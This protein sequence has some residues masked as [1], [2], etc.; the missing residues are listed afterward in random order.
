M[1]KRFKFTGAYEPHFL[2][3]WRDFRGMSL[4]AMVEAIVAL[5]VVTGGLTKASLSRI[6]T[7]KTPYT[8][9]TLEAYAAV[10]GCHPADL[11]GRAPVDPE[12]IWTIWARLRQTDR[13]RAVA[14]LS[15]LI[16]GEES[17]STEA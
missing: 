11:L 7:G 9:D 2:R 6:E 10:L 15:L 17:R 8:R 3:Q 4:D 12:G 13:P 16:P 1:A 14:L 5:D